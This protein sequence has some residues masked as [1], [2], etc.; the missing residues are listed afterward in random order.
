MCS[1]ILWLAVTISDTGSS[2]LENTKALQGLLDVVSS[3]QSL[4]PSRPSAPLAHL[5]GQ[6]LPRMLVTLPDEKNLEATYLTH[7]L[8]I[9]RNTTAIQPEGVW[10]FLHLDQGNTVLK[11]VIGLVACLHPA[12][13]VEAAGLLGNIACVEDGRKT[14]VPL[15]FESALISTL[16]PG[17]DAALREASMYALRQALGLDEANHLVQVRSEPASLSGHVSMWPVCHSLSSFTN[18]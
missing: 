4:L 11:R 15:G 12:A 6:T 1:R 10:R 13:S 14:L 3:S 7:V 9:L 16:V 2:I 8:G 5:Y 18:V 17:V